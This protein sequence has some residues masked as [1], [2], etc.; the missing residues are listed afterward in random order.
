VLHGDSP[1]IITFGVMRV[2]IRL[3]HRFHEINPLRGI[4]TALLHVVEREWF[5]ANSIDEA[6]AASCNW[7]PARGRR[8][9]AVE[10]RGAILGRQQRGGHLTRHL[11]TVHALARLGR[12]GERA[13]EMTKVVTLE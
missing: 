8:R 7:S 12:I 4:P 6:D 11:G 3:V 2:T 10:L 5:C 9:R 1:P 13:E